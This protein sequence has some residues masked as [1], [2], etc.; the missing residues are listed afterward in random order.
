MPLLGG[1]VAH[2]VHTKSTGRKVGVLLP[3]H[4]QNAEA[5]LG[6]LV[7]FDSRRKK[8]VQGRSIPLEAGKILFFTGVRY[9]RSDT[10]LPGKNP[11][12][13]RPKRKRG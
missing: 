10:A 5:G 2:I 4:H 7:Q 9:E 8:L 12:T 13:T 1:R 3:V 11:D 6:K